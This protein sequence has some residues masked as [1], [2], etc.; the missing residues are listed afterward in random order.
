MQEVRRISA[1]L[2]FYKVFALQP[3]FYTF[4]ERLRKVVMAMPKEMRFLITK[5][6]YGFQIQSFV[7]IKFG[8]C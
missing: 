3:F 1:I 4:Y 5:V 6:F 8:N 7:R 2:Y